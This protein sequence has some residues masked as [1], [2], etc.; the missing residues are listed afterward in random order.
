MKTLSKT[1]AMI[2]ARKLVT[3]PVEIR[4]GWEVYGPA[5]GR[6]ITIHHPRTSM[7]RPDFFR[8]QEL[9]TTWIT[10][11]ALWLMGHKPSDIELRALTGPVEDRV[12]TY[13]RSREVQHETV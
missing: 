7:H 9:R 2:A 8:A 4:N 6:D 11:L 1:A 3:K 5:D 10:H 13:L 12:R